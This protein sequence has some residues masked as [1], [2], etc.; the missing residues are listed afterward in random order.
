MSCHQIPGHFRLTPPWGFFL[1]LGAGLLIQ[2]GLAPHGPGPPVGDTVMVN[3][4]SITGP[5]PG[6]DPV[7]GGIIEGIVGGLLP[8]LAQGP[9][10]L[11]GLLDISIESHRCLLCSK[12]SPQR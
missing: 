10:L 2:E 11:V 8:S 3:L 9:L 5:D 1:F 12:H 4:V 7:P 6:R